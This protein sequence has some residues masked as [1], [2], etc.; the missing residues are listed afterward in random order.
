MNIE[1]QTWL[2]AGIEEDFH[3]W[4][5]FNPLMVVAFTNRRKG[6]SKRRFSDVINFVNSIVKMRFSSKKNEKTSHSSH[7]K[8]WVNSERRRLRY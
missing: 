3:D 6:K 4:K 5:R 2:N 1:G 8:S 7:I